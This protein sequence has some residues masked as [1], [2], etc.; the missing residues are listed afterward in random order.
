ME[1]LKRDIE[2][3]LRKAYFDLIEERV[4]STPPD[5]DWLVKLYSEIVKKITVFLKINSPI[6]VKIEDNMDVE[7]FSQMIKNNAFN[8]TDMIQL[9]KYTFDT[10]MLLGSPGRDNDIIEMK[11]NIL[12]LIKKPDSTFGEVVSL[13]LK[14]AHIGIDNYHRDF[15]NSIKNYDI[16]K[17]LKDL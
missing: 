3:Q 15:E 5:Y 2:S 8:S 9:V 6:R 16:I 4:N 7:L 14:N 10:L 17:D 13:Y 11:T 12:D 1:N